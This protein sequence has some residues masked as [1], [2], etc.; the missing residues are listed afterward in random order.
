MIKP[1]HAAGGIISP[2]TQGS[3]G[4]ILGTGGTAPETNPGTGG[5]AI[6]SGGV[7]GFGGSLGTGGKVGSGGTGGTATTMHTGGAIGSGGVSATGGTRTSGGATGTGGVSTTGGNLHTGGVTATGGVGGVGGRTMNGGSLGSGGR[8]GFGGSLATGGRTSTGGTSGTGGYCG[9][10]TIGPGE[11]CDLGA[12]NK[13]APAF[14][15]TQAGLSFAATPLVRTDSSPYFYSYSSSSAHTG[16]EALGTSRVLLHVDKTTLVLSL[17]VIHGVDNDSTGLDQPLSRVVM[18]FSGLPTT[19]TVGLA[20]DSDEFLMTS[21]TTATGFWKFTGNSDGGVLFGLPF[22]GDWEITIEP[23]FLDG[24][25]VWTWV[26]SDGSLVNL[27][28]TQPVTI[29]AYQAASPCRLDCT[30]P[31]CGDGLL[32]GGEICDDGQPSDGQSMCGGDCMSFNL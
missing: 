5:S 12:D 29:K 23:S 18:S 16:L 22:P 13:N 19:T 28:L 17:I 11:Q 20:D 1:R 9:N 31:R 8:L 32:D 30:A 27:D 14:W 4:N 2:A 6:R 26:Q 24:I 10:G 3:G 15:V 21:S 25:S 7:P